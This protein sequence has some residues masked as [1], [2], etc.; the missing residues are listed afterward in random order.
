[1][2]DDNEY[3]KTDKIKQDFFYE[4]LD[5]HGK[6]F[7][8]GMDIHFPKDLNPDLIVEFNQR[9]IALE[10]RDG[11]DPKY[12]MSKGEHDSK[13]DTMFY[14]GLIFD[15][16]MTHN[17]T[18]HFQNAKKVLQKVIGPKY[19]AEN[20]VDYN[21][22]EFETNGLITSHEEFGPYK[23]ETETF[24]LFDLASYDP[25][26]TPIMR[27]PYYHSPIKEEDDNEI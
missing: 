22:P 16:N 17:T 9:F 14:M 3:E 20:R 8:M 15:G 18:E 12:F 24:H 2:Y 1:M 7:V 10:S 11:Y 5:E 13:G 25:D 19:S 23:N 4:S 21:N 6:V 27:K 26:F